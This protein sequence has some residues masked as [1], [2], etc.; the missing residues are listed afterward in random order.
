MVSRMSLSAILIASIAQI[1][2]LFFLCM[3]SALLSNAPALASLTAACADLVQTFCA[4]HGWVLFSSYNSVHSLFKHWSTCTLQG[5]A[6]NHKSLAVIHVL[7]FCS[8][9]LSIFLYSYLKINQYNTCRCGL[10]TI[11]SLVSAPSHFN[12]RATVTCAP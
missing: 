12:S 3:L 1:H 6:T 5:T 11:W 8:R 10:S 9:A 2:L 4:N 7:S